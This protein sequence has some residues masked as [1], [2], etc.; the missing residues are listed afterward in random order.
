MSQ[1]PGTGSRVRASERTL[2]LAL[3]AAKDAGLPV[4]RLCISGGKI[5]IHFGGVADGAPAKPDG[6]LKEW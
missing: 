2:R 1:K 3:Q 5:E 6:R 4:D